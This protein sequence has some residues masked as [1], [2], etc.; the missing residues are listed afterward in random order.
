MDAA[1][2]KLVEIDDILHRP[3]HLH[4]RVGRQAAVPVGGVRLRSSGVAGVSAARGEKKSLKAARYSNGANWGKTRDPDE[5][6][7][8]FTRWPD[9]N[10]GIPTGVE[11]GI[12][13]VEADTVAGHGVDGIASLQALEEKHGQ[14]AAY[15]HG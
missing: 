12:F 8:D 2:S 13:V 1:F 3:G 14:A 4:R 15:A 10:V 7:S 6:E 9:A 11:N 5:I